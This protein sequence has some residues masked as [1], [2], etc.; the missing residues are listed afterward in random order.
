MSVARKNLPA[1]D[2]TWDKPGLMCGNELGGWSSAGNA[3]ERRLFVIKFEEMV[4]AS[5]PKYVTPT[6]APTSTPY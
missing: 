1:V 3:M 4:T 6:L 2:L 5:D